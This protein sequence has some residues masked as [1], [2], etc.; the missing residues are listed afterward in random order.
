MM[1]ETPT[2]VRAVMLFPLVE[3]VVVVVEVVEAIEVWTT[4]WTEELS[5]VI[6]EWTMA[7]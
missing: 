6:P 1:V 5:A 7:I 3:E 2:E 4:E